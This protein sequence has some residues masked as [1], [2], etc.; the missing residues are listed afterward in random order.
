[1]TMTDLGGLHF[2]IESSD[3]MEKSVYSI[4]CFFIIRAF[5]SAFFRPQAACTFAFASSPHIICKRCLLSTDFLQIN[6][7]NG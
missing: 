2:F 3:P 1:M 6:P 5:S 7:H 4:T